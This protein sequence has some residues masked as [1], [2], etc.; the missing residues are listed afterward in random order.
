MIVIKE[1]F[2]LESWDFEVETKYPY[3]PLTDYFYF[4]IYLN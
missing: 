3:Q 2:G 4:K 1:N